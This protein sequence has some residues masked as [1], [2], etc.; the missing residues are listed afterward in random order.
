MCAAGAIA[1][2][3]FATAVFAGEKEVGNRII[4]VTD[5]GVIP[6][7]LEINDQDLTVFLLNRSKESLITFEID[8]GKR[9][10]HCS[11]DNIENLEGGKSRSV[12]PLAPRDFAATCF[13]DPGTYPIKFYGVAGA[14][15]PIT[16]KVVLK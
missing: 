3:F 10:M 8:Y 13:H 7:V 6:Q 9:E 11:N 15:E 5:K 2:L 12:K 1:A 4:E 16:A 14:K